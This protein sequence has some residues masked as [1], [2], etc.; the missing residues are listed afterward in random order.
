MSKEHILSNGE[1]VLLREENSSKKYYIGSVWK[2]TKCGNI[3]VV[4]KIF[5]YYKYVVQFSDGNTYVATPTAIK[6]GVI[7][8]KYGKDIKTY[9]KYTLS[10]GQDVQ[11]NEYNSSE[12]FCDDTKWKTTNFGYVLVIGQVRKKGA[13]M[14]VV[15]FNDNNSYLV[16]S[17]QLTKGFIANNHEESRETHVLSNGETVSISLRN[18]STKIQTGSF[19]TTRHDGR[20]EVLGQV[21]V[22]KNVRKFIVQ[23]SDGNTYLRQL[24]EILTGKI[25]NKYKVENTKEITLTNKEVVSMRGTN[26]SKKFYTGSIWETTNDGKI[27]VLGQVTTKN[28]QPQ[29]VVQFKDKHTY[30]ARTKSIIS[31]CI[32]NSIKKYSEHTLANGTKVNLREINTSKNIPNWFRMGN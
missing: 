32:Q 17:V 2:T 31:G 12:K 8:N 11:M 30:L 27:T 25:N 14:Y 22:S 15:Q 23:F 9:R 13:T 24:T 16:D 20:I 26:T 18:T 3:K 7:A 29:Y 21:A 10:N 5:D 4:G 6:T 19:W 28:T 1:R